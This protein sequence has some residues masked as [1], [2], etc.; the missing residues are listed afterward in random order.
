MTIYVGIDGGFSGGIVAINNDQK[1]IG[2][3][4]MPVIKGKT[5]EYDVDNIVDI[6]EK[7]QQQD[8]D[9]KVIL[10]KAHP[11]PISGKRQCFTTGDCYGIMKGV[12]TAMYISYEIVNPT[13]WM[14]EMFK[15]M[16]IK[17]KKVSIMWCKRKY[18]KEDFRAS[19]RCKN[20]H[21]GLTDA[22]CLAVYGFR[23]NK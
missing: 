9:I 2:K 18:P 19:E 5:S 17:D 20:E 13:V 10:E 1:I 6:F 21:D 3:W 15:G 23:L 8:N 16:N 22:T 7:L 12:L 14:K 4:I 11:R